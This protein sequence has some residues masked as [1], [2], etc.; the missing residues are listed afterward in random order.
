MLK[1]IEKYLLKVIKGEKKGILANLLKV[2]LFLL[3]IVFFVL[4]KIR[5]FLYKIKIFKIKEVNTRVISIGNITVGGTGKTPALELLARL[6][7]NS[8]KKVAIVSRGYGSETKESLIV[9]NNKEILLDV[10]KAGDEVYLLANL[11]A[12]IPIVKGQNRWQAAK[13]AEEKF[14]PDLILLDDG[15]QHLALKRDLDIIIIDA[16]NPFGYNH[17]LPR[18]FLREPLKALKRAHLFI[19]SRVNQVSSSQVKQIKDRLKA[20]NKKAKILT[21]EHKSAYLRLLKA[22][23]QEKDYNLEKIRD[24]KALAVSGIGNPKSFVYSLNDLGVNVVDTVNYPDHY[25]YKVEDFT[26]LAIKAQKQGVNFLITTEKDMVKI[27][28]EMINHLNK[29]NL[30]IYVLGIELNILEDIDLVKILSQHRY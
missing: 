30:D 5:M 10:K 2:F 29:C 15:F 8:G 7:A 4:I 21:S 22:S 6:Y 9:A 20:Y 1:D 17:L 28:D 19:I 3:E 26:E 12:N 14:Q 13:L 11:L 24:K 27:S 16:L 23:K 18:G 25:Q